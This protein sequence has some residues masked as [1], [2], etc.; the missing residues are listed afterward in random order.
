MAGTNRILTAYKDTTMSNEPFTD[1]I[2]SAIIDGE[3]DPD[4]VAAVAGDPVAAA[5]LAQ[6]EA[7][8]ALVAEPPA[9]AEPERRSSSIAAA[10]A[11]ATPA[12]EVSSLA[13][14][15][16]TRE[17][18]TRRL[19]SRRW[20]GVAAA[21]LALVVAIPLLANLRSESADSIA[22]AEDRSFATDDADD[23]VEESAEAM[24]EADTLTE[25]AGSNDSLDA[26]QAAGDAAGDDEADE[27]MDEDTSADDGAIEEEVAEESASATTTARADLLDQALIDAPVFSNIEILDE[28]IALGSV[29]PVLTLDEVIQLGV[30][31]DCAEPLAFTDEPQFA[32]AYL[33]SGDTERRLILISFNEDQTTIARDA[34]DCSE[35]G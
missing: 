6:L 8:V 31:P 32:V 28:M 20:L 33:D 10:M 3:A 24:A 35:L 19:D 16:H 22:T 2:L 21:A 29:A 25:S 4:T 17:Q 11:A 5:R 14:A 1:E 12:P 13:A 23:A 9:V 27:A 15:R 18:N 7:V 26:P 30:S 34:D